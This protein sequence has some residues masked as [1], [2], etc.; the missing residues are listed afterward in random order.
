MRTAQPRLPTCFC[1]DFKNLI[2][3]ICVSTDVFGRGDYIKCINGAVNY[4]MS[5]YSQI[6]GG[7]D[8]DGLAQAAETYL[9][10]VGR[11]SRFGTKWSSAS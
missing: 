11:A 5:D 1:I 3:G 7:N 9:H 8:K 2:Q 4:G 10:P 6:L